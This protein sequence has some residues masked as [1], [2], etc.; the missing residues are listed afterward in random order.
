MLLYTVY[1]LSEKG[2]THLVGIRE[3]TIQVCFWLA[4]SRIYCL[5][6]QPG[7]AGCYVLYVV[8]SRLRRVWNSGVANSF[9]LLVSSAH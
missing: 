3:N 6:E 7:N 9:V 8:C 1:I 2:L 4:F 5:C